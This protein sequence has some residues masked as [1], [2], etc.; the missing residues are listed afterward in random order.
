MVL[1]VMLLAWLL[2]VLLGMRP[3]VVLGSDFVLGGNT[4]LGS[5]I[6]RIRTMRM[7][8][9]NFVLGSNI[10]RTRVMVLLVMLLA[11]LLVVL[12]GM[13][14]VM[15]RLVSMFRSNFVLRGN[16][17]RSSTT[18]RVSSVRLF[19]SDLMLGSNTIRSSTTGRV[20]S[21]RL[22][23]S[24]LMLGS[25]TGRSSTSWPGCISSARSRCFFMLGG[26][27]GWLCTVAAR[28]H[29]FVKRL[30]T[31]WGF[32]SC[33][34]TPKKTSIGA[35]VVRT[36]TIRTSI[37]IVKEPGSAPFISVV[38]EWN[39]VSTMKHNWAFIVGNN[40]GSKDQ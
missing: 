22:F 16:A 27:T 1:L 8:G 21:M 5:S 28:W 13:L 7:F 26:Y 34:A 25:N 23:G 39:M 37:I 29:G 17:I 11:W 4:I 12:L 14:L 36:S 33:I 3:V 32:H 35:E 30:N 9:S 15:M 20:S 19:G 2:V 6:R 38:S 18:S 40:G 24:D 31:T 10:R